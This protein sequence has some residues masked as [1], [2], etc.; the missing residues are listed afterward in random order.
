M[1]AEQNRLHYML[2]VVYVGY[3]RVKL[4]FTSP[5]VLLTNPIT[6]SGG[7]DAPEVTE[8]APVIIYIVQKVT[9]K[10]FQYHLLDTWKLNCYQVIQKLGFKS[11]PGGYSESVCV[12][13]SECP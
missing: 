9:E 5:L 11:F 8:R 13:V 7:D 12:R 4:Y 1:V 10:T 6:A 3:Y 2:H